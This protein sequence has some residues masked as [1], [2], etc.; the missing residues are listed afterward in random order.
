VIEDSENRKQDSAEGI[1]VFVVD[2]LEAIFFI[3]DIE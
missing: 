1:C 3:G 2:H